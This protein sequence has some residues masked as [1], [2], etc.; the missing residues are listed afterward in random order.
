MTLIDELNTLAHLREQGGLTD[1]EFTRA[2]EQV[3]NAAGTR[4]KLP[5]AAHI[6]AF[7]RSRTDHWFGGVCGGLGQLTDTA[8]WIWRLL[9]TGL[10]LMAG[11]GLPLYIL[12]WIF[13]PKA[14]GQPCSQVGTTAQPA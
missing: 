2:K 13:V 5:V 12:L 8:A 14:D 11:V 6:N 7:R 1:A 9:F 4:P 3:M 10:F